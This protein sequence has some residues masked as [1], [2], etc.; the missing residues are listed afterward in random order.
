MLLIKFNPQFSGLGNKGNEET[1]KLCWLNH[2]KPE[3]Y[4]AGA[5]LARIFP[6]VYAQF[7]K[8]LPSSK[9]HGLE[10]ATKSWWNGNKQHNNGLKTDRDMKQPYL[11]FRLG[12]YNSW[13]PQPVVSE[14]QYFLTNITF[15]WPT[16]LTISQISPDNGL[17]SS[18]TAI[19]R[20]FI[21][22]FSE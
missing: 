5:Y 4:F 22:A 11:K 2:C 8:S 14:I 16:E 12:T 3:F 17:N 6:A 18:L 20:P 7:V 9:Q 21:S 19:P 13:L 15:S 1:I 10:T